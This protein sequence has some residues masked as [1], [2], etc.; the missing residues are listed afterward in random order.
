[1]EQHPERMPWE[2]DPDV[3][4]ALNKIMLL[5]IGPSGENLAPRGFEVPDPSSKLCVRSDV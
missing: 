3:I 5:G 1:M 2:E 4:V